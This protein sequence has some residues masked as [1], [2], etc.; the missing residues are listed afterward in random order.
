ME[1]AQASTSMLATWCDRDI[2]DRLHSIKGS[3]PNLKDEILKQSFVALFIFMWDM[4]SD[5]VYV[6]NQ[7]RRK[8]P[9]AASLNAALL[10]RSI[11]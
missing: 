3:K 7:I 10:L 11:S 9:N 1:P 4:L 6:Y 2:V 5:P 8:M